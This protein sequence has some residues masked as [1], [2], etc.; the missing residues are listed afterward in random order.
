MKH[1]E[2][3]YANTYRIKPVVFGKFN[4]SDTALNGM[5]KQVACESQPI[6]NYFEKNKNHSSIIVNPAEKILLHTIPIHYQGKMFIGTMHLLPILY[7]NLCS[8]LLNMSEIIIGYINNNK[9]NN[10][11]G[12]LISEENYNAFISYKISSIIMLHTAIDATL[13]YIFP[14]DKTY[15]SKKANKVIGKLEFEDLPFMDKVKECF[16]V[17]FDYNICDEKNY[18]IINEINN[19]RINFVHINTTPD[20]LSIA[21]FFGEL[22][23]ALNIDFKEY[24]VNI[25]DLF[26]K[27]R[28]DLFIIESTTINHGQ[29]LQGENGINTIYYPIVNNIKSN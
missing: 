13:N 18:N 27:F 3:N 7:F 12:I 19:H 11:E 24:L 16:R 15:F 17:V 8:D 29:I 2:K 20:G 22:G 1:T 25:I 26:K 4:I 23:A 5:E 6:T 9:E 21:K 14:N 28:P 10:T